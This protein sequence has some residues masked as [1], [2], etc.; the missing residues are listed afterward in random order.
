MSHDCRKAFILAS[1]E[2][3]G[4]AALL[5]IRSVMVA[6]AGCKGEKSRYD[7]SQI[8][9]MAS[10]LAWMLSRFS[11][12]LLRGEHRMS[13]AILGDES[14]SHMNFQIILVRLVSIVVGI[15][16]AFVRNW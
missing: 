12:P 8:I 6:Q 10:F 11:P 15:P 2:V 14:S 13:Y 3:P 7:L 1:C 9:S 16:F 4:G 5:M